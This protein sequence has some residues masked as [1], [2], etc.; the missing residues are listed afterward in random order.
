M[1][2]IMALSVMF[3]VAL[4]SVSTASAAWQ[5]PFWEAGQTYH[6]LNNPT[7]E[8]AQERTSSRTWDYRTQFIGEDVKHDRYDSNAIRAT[9]NNEK[10]EVD[11]NAL[12][13]RNR[14]TQHS[15]DYRYSIK[16]DVEMTTTTGKLNVASDENLIPYTVRQIKP[17]ASGNELSLKHATRF[18]SRVIQS[19]E[20]SDTELARLGVERYDIVCAAKFYEENTFKKVLRPKVVK[21]VEDAD[22]C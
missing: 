6:A 3:L 5:S 2:K 11:P 4:L 1:K 13:Q 20:V 9:A 17:T 18:T 10:I 19:S 22:M 15:S 14:K 12:D 8:K 7:G 16:Q 21:V